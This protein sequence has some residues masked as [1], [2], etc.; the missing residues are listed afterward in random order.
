MSFAHFYILGLLASFSFLGTLYIEKL[1]LCLY[2]SC[3]YFFSLPIL[4]LHGESFV[5]FFFFVAE[6]INLFFYGF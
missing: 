6:F 3:N 4:L 1:S 5:F 2:M